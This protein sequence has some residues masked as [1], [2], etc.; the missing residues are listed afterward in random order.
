MLDDEPKLISGSGDAFISID[1]NMD[2][3]L[4]ARIL[5]EELDAALL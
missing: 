3:N 4:R 2:D 5:A 1:A